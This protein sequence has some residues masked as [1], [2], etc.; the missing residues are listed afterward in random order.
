MAVEVQA[1]QDWLKQFNDGELVG[2]DE[3]G[4]TLVVYGEGGDLEG[5]PEFEVGGL[6]EK[7]DAPHA[8]DCLCDACTCPR[9]GNRKHEGRCPRAGV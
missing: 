5:C 2:V 1:L 3:G 9:C 8:T 4:L 6:P 7:D